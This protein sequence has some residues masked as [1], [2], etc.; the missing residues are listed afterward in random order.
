VRTAVR[1]VFVIRG[2]RRAGEALAPPVAARGELV[3]LR[4][5]PIVHV[6]DELA[7][8]DEELDDGS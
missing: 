8:L 3:V 4:A 5:Q 6:A 7:V 2:H 1:M